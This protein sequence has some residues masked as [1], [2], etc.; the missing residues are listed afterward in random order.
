MPNP[1]QEPPV[2]SNAINEDFKYMDNL[3]TFKIKTKSLN[4][5]YGS[6]KDQLPYPNQ[7]QEP[8]P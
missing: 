2:S 4:L 7:D 5:E 1:S 8:K 6:I 3:C